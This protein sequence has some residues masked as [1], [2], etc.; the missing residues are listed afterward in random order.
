MR[1][2]MKGLTFYLV[3][4][5]AEEKYAGNQLAVV[6]NAGALSSA[7]MQR[8]A[9]EMHF[10]ETAFIISDEK[11]NG[12][13]DV[14]IFTPAREMPFAGHPTLGTAYVI[15]HSL[16]NEDVD[17]VALNLKVGQI[18][19]TFEK[20]E[21]QEI[22]WMKQVPPV[23]GKTYDAADISQM[24]NLSLEDI[25]NKYPAQEVSTGVPFVIVPLKTLNAV[26]RVR[27]DKDKH[28][29]LARETQA[30]TLVFSPETYKK[31]NT[32]NARVFVDLHGIPEDPAAGS[33]NGCLAAY[34]SKYRYFGDDAV[35]ARVEQGYEIGRPSLLRIRA[36]KR[37]GEIQVH[38]G[39][40]VVM[41]ANGELT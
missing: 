39:G 15:R 29:E 31:E 16:V 23:F 10:S 6:R 3:D 36:E 27:I 38:V 32:L 11:R 34:L 12:G 24:L 8:I 13:Y 5:F 14:R 37:E 1:V 26:K 35:S 20:E 17:K 4:V 40:K 25:D 41:V 19:V 9:N 33:A 7:Q 28:L 22:L 18:P 30:E 21:D 2:I